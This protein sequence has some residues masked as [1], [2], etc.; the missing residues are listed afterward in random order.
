MEQK[1]VLKTLSLK[2]ETLLSLQEKQMQSVLGGAA[3]YTSGET[4]GCP[5]SDCNGTCC[6]KS[7][8]GGGTSPTTPQPP[9]PAPVS[10]AS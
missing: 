3:L 7:C 10:V 2:K 4:S 9:S 8:S 5:S 1:K 6:K